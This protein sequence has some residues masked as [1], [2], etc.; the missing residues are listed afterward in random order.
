MDFAANY[1]AAKIFSY[2]MW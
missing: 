2:A 1:R